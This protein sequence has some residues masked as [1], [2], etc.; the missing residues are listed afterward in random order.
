MTGSRVGHR[1]EQ[2]LRVLAVWAGVLLT[3]L[4]AGG[5]SARAAT[6]DL[7]TNQY[8]TMAVDDARQHV[9]VALP[10]LNRVDVFDYAGNL[11]GT[12]P[13]L[14]GVWGLTIN[15]NTLYAVE[16]NSGSIAAIDLSAA[17]PTPRT[18]V[19]G[20]NAPLWLVFTGGRLW[21]TV[22]NPN[23][24][25]GGQ[26]VSV[27]P[28]SGTVTALPDGYYGPD[29][30][31]SPGAP[32]ALFA[33]EDGLSP[34]AIYRFDTCASPVTVSAQWDRTDQENIQDVT[35]S[36]DGSRVV[37]VGG[38]P[39]EFE[40]LG[41]TTLQPDG[42][43]YPAQ[44]YPTA[45]AS[46][47]SGLLATGLNGNDSPNVSV[48]R[49]GTPAAA[50]STTLTDGSAPSDIWPH[51]VALSSDG[52]HVF[53]IDSS[54]P[55]SAGGADVR[56]NA[57][58]TGLSVPV[59]APQRTGGT[60]PGAGAGSGTS[61]GTGPTPGSS[62]SATHTKPVDVRTAVRREAR[63]IAAAAAAAKRATA[64]RSGSRTLTRMIT[65]LTKLR[66]T[67]AA[68]AT[69]V[70]RSHA[71]TRRLAR[72]RHDWVT[73]ARTLATSLGEMAG[74]LRALRAHHLTSARRQARKSAAAL[75]RGSTAIRRAD[76]ELGVK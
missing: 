44:A 28:T 33:T 40:E 1:G 51:G 18:I 47:P 73:G 46:G 42:V 27:D 14:Y 34:G 49:Y 58:A 22:Q 5:T 54:D 20:L 21:T 39:Y 17:T 13:N 16:R 48:F 45:A 26:I 67:V 43:R 23:V 37:P 66:R 12:I 64:T 32:G 36:P 52:S 8:G 63:V 6:V 74:A 53:V 31:V 9:L 55:N 56:F 41:A 7:G 60:C 15:A 25:Y 10:A 59:S 75:R 35:V 38:A 70:S 69:Y 19:S 30:A 4:V 29:L 76:R 65:A 24:T 3:C 62:S 11:V 72:G 68:A 2:A 57:L 61:G 71:A 50:W